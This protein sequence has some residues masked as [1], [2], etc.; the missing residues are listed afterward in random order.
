MVKR[1][2]SLLQK[3]LTAELVE[4]GA[5]L[6]RAD[7]RECFEDTFEILRGE[8]VADRRQSLDTRVIREYACLNACES[9]TTS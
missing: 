8:A 9:S 6:G 2:P 4:R 1:R 5:P 7:E 3:R